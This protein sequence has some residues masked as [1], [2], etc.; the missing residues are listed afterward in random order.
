MKIG[1]SVIS[2]WAIAKTASIVVRMTVILSEVAFTLEPTNTMGFRTKIK[3]YMKNIRIVSEL[4]PS[5]TCFFRNSSAR[6]S[7]RS[8]PACKKA[9]FKISRGITVVLVRLCVSRNVRSGDHRIRLPTSGSDRL[10]CVPF[11]LH[12]SQSRSLQRREPALQDPSVPV[13]RL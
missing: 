8:K 12:P 13:S 11:H 1:F 5:I 4:N 10:S 9:A 6:Q 2:L 3:T 7:F